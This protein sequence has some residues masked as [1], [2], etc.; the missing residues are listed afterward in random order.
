MEWS[1]R[2]LPSELQRKLDQPIKAPCLRDDERMYREL[3]ARLG[4]QSELVVRP[5]AATACLG[6]RAT[7]GREIL[8]SEAVDDPD[9]GMDQNLPDSADPAGDRK[10]MGGATGPTSQGFR[11]MYFGGWSVR[12]PVATFQVPV[13]EMGQSP[14]RVEKLAQVAR[15]FFA[16]GDAAWGYRVLAWATHFIQD[17]AQP[18]HSVQIPN[19]K[20]VP[21]YA[22]LTWPPSRAFV[23]LVAE[24]TRSISNYHFAYEGYTLYRLG[25]R[26]K[27]PFSDCL[28]QA[29]ELSKIQFDAVNETP[30]GL[31]FEV[32]R[33]SI[34]LGGGL[35][36]GVLA[37]FGGGLKGRDHD[38][39]RGVGVPNYAELSIRPEL[40]EQRARLDAISCRALS[41]SMV[42][43][44]FLSEWVLRK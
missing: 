22:L 3:S 21:W 6:N 44:R 9:N 23:E 42:A 33:R 11:H 12:A 37:F 18:F 28:P 1:I 10:W 36:S 7:S 39:P 19:L 17:L 38:L 15:E 2:E 14:E 30:R 25:Q 35:G 43:T 5:T 27:G 34:N 4:L 29:R 20:L 13:R 8:L 16:R 24:T 31:A 40:L 26:E 41:N 32:A